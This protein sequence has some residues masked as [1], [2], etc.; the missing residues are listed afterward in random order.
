MVRSKR[1]TVHE[2]QYQGASQD[3]EEG[4]AVGV[5]I[6][7]PMIYL[8]FP[9]DFRIPSPATHY[10]RYEHMHFARWLRARLG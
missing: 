7:M 6:N 1:D 10:Y 2:D 5:L 8:F 9:V 4:E 3:R